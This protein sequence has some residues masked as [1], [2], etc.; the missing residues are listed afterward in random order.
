MTS[1][2]FFESL[3]QHFKNELPFVAYRNPSV[4]SLKA[5]LQQNS[6]RYITAD[7][8]ENGFVFAPFDDK[9][10]AVFI[11]L[12][13]SKILILKKVI[14]N[15]PIAIGSEESNNLVSETSSEEK[16]NHINLVQK[17]IDAIK[18]NL[19]QK[20]VLSRQEPITISETNPISI[21]KRLLKT[22]ASAFV[23]LWYHPKVGLWLGATPETLLKVEGKPLKEH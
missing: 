4:D 21:F 19:F 7:F 14:L 17:G 22:Y 1:E 3:S 6:E 23:Y 9:K 11:P 12:N 2:D 8:K 10:D 15:V 18:A 13:K 16:Q 20:V 5:I